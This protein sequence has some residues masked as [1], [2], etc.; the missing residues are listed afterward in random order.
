MKS[1][2]IKSNTE[3]RNDGEQGVSVARGDASGVRG[4]PHVLY[5]Q[6][7]RAFKPGGGTAFPHCPHC[8]TSVDAKEATLLLLSILACLFP[9]HKVLDQRTITMLSGF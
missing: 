9:L 6:V 3:A 1:A 7:Q 2:A 8:G 5:K 4:F